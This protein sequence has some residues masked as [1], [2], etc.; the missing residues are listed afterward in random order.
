[1]AEYRS[2]AG[3]VL[4]EI[5]TS[6]TRKQRNAQRMINIEEKGTEVSWERHSL[7]R[8]LK[9]LKIWDIFATDVINQLEKLE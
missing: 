8:R 2:R 1:M 3:K 7:V 9:R 6:F 5:R 4:N